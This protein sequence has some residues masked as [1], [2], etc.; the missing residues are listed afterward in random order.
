MRF[1]NNYL[2]YYF[3]KIIP[4]EDQKFKLFEIILSYDCNLLHL[5]VSK[6]NISGKCVSL[7]ELSP[8][9]I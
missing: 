7:S 4:T 6:S 3:E 9:K 1:I 8:P 5:F 2:N